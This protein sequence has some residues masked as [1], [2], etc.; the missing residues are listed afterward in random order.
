[1]SYNGLKR[2]ADLCGAAQMIILCMSVTINKPFHFTQKILISGALKQTAREQ[3]NANPAET[4]TLTI[5]L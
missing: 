5:H 3:C 1:M 2:Y 4:L